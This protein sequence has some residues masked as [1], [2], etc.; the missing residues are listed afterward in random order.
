MA[1]NLS[2]EMGIDNEFVKRHY[3]CILYAI[4]YYNE[5]E[6]VIINKF[7]N[8]FMFCFISLSLS[9]SLRFYLQLKIKN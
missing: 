3:C 7:I 9:L 5:A 2:K 8:Y 1:L 6:K 4:G